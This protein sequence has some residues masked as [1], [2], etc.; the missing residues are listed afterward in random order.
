MKWLRNGYSKAI[1]VVGVLISALFLA[2]ALVELWKLL[3][4]R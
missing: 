3:I 2:L 4:L 1:I